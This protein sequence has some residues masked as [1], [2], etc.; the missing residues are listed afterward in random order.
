MIKLHRQFKNVDGI[1]ICQGLARGGEGK[2]MSSKYARE[3]NIPF[4]GI[5]LGM[6]CAIVI[7]PE[8]LRS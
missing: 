6:Q 4:L 2:I 7:L 5:C 3:N 8:C 1:L